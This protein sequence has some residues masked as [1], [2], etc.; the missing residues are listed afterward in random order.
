M[1]WSTAETSNPDMECV[2]EEKTK[3]SLSGLAEELSWLGLGARTIG[4]G[5]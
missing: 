5:G 4:L 1:I 2:E 3:V